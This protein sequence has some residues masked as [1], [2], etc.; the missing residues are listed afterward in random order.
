[1]GG[2]AL[3]KFDL[4][5][6]KGRL[7]LEK[8]YE[9]ATERVLTSY[10]DDKKPKKKTFEKVD[11]FAAEISYFSDCVMKDRVPEPSAH[12]GRADIRVIQAI[13][14]SLDTGRA[15]RLNPE[16]TKLRY[17]QIKHKMHKPP[18]KEPK[19]VNVS[20]PTT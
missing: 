7:Q 10:K 14:K 13:L 4:V 3:A 17:P 9:Y 8:A 19:T 1:L 16:K 20:A 11:Q 18:V 2:V 6:S 5:G 15:I 12:E